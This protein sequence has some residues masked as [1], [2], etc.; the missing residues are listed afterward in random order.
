[1]KTIKLNEEVVQQRIGSEADVVKQALRGHAT[2]YE[3]RA[4]QHNDN[5]CILR[6]HNLKYRWRNHH[7]ARDDD[8][9]CYNHNSACRHHHN[10][11]FRQALPGKEGAWREQPET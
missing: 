7:G 10:N 9:A 6:Q 1:M 2:E 5:V 3:R 4:E 8:H 11:G